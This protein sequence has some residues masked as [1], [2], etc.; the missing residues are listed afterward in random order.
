MKHSNTFLVLLTFTILL[1]ACSLLPSAPSEPV[2]EL[3]QTLTLPPQPTKTPLRGATD[4]PAPVCTP[5]LCQENESYY[6][7]DECPG[8]CGTTC[9]THTP[10]MD[11]QQ[12]TVTI[13]A[14]VRA[15]SFPNPGDYQ[16]KAIADGLSSPVGLTHAGDGSERLFILE[17]KGMIR[18]LSDGQLQTA[19]FLDIHARVGSGG[20][21]QGLLGLAFHPDYADNGFFLLIRNNMQIVCRSTFMYYNK[22]LFNIL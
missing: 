17:Q 16:W 13:P 5:P 2:K 10:T 21:E 12:P 7:P 9:A 14:L 15:Q 11:E 8:G 19:P 18:I 4:T 6:C 22:Q 20:N 1:T 3:P